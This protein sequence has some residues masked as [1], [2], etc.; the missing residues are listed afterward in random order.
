M[1]EVSERQS[2]SIGV[3]W[4]R[5]VLGRQENFRDMV[6]LGMRQINLKVVKIKVLV[7]W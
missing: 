3:R 4:A 5:L 1:D 2:I 7:D 6:S